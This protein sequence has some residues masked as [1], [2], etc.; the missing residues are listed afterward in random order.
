M[1]GQN[2]SKSLKR[3]TSI[4][5]LICTSFNY[6][7]SGTMNWELQTGEWYTQTRGVIFIQINGSVRYPIKIMC[8]FHY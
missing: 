1:Y 4:F 5:K 2:E 8:G 7:V 6:R 3:K